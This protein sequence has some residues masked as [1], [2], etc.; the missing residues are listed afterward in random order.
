MSRARTPLRQRITDTVNEVARWRLRSD[1][2]VIVDEASLAGTFAL[3]E[4]VRAAATAGAKVVL[5]GDQAQLSSVD[6]GGMFAALVRDRE[7]L[8]PELPTCAAFIT[9]GRKGPAS[10]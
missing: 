2:L 3:D 5:V 7:G 1:Q 10:S 9:P 6:A 8:A 4:L